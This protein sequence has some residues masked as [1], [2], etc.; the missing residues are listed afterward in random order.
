MKKEFQEEMKSLI[1]E[2]GL[3]QPKVPTS[4]DEAQERHRSA[5]SGPSIAGSILNSSIAFLIAVSA[6]TISRQGFSFGG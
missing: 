1:D 6:P 2:E 3:I 4:E 5:T